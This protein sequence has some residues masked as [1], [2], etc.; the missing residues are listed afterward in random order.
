[1][2]DSG[3]RDTNNGSKATVNYVFTSPN[4]TSGTYTMYT[5]PT[6]NG[7]ANWHGIYVGATATTSGNGTSLTA[8]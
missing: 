3:L 2:T 8:Q 4:V 6:I 5:N 1:M 7:T